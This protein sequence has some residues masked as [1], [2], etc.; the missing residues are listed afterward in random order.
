MRPART[1]FFVAS[2][3]RFFTVTDISNEPVEDITLG[4]TIGCHVFRKYQ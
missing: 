1:R 4:V 3:N 2:S